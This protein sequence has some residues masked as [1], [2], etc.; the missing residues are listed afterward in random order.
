MTTET[1]GARKAALPFGAEKLDYV[2]DMF[3]AI[4]PRYD[5]LNTLMTF[6]LDRHWRRRAVAALR[7]ARGGVVLDLAAGTGALGG[8]LTAAGLRGAGCDLSFEMLRH[9]T[10]GAAPAFQGDAVALPIAA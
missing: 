8:A 1:S 3:D 5:L 4:A 7:L 2:R 6:G 9:P 10:P